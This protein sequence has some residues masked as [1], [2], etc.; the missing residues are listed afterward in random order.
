MTIAL[1]AFAFAAVA[2]AS[3]FPHV[4]NNGR[5]VTFDAWNTTDKQVRCTGP[6]YMTMDDS[7]QDTIYVHEYLWPRQSMN[8]TYYPNSVGKTIRSVSHGV[9]CW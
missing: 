9:W 8:R 4:W 3:V 5:S 6:I 1:I 7:S 2:N